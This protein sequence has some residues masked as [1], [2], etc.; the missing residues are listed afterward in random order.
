MP[1]ATSADPGTVILGPSDAHMAF[2]LAQA[3]GNDAADLITVSQLSAYQPGV[4]IGAV[5]VDSH[6]VLSTWGISD[7]NG[8]H[9][10]ADHMAGITDQRYRF[11]TADV[12]RPGKWF[13]RLAVA[14]ETGTAG[15]FW[16]AGDLLVSGNV[17][18]YGVFGT[19]L[20]LWNESTDAW[21][22]T[23]SNLTAAPVNTG[24]AFAGTGTL[25]LFI[26][27]G[28]SG[29]ATYTGAVFANVAASGTVPAA[30]A[31]CVF[32]NTSL[33]CLATNGQ[34]W[35]SVD[36]TA[37][38]SFGADGKVD[39]ALTANWIYE[40]RDV[41]GNPVLMVVTT[42]GVFSFDPA[43]PTLY[44]LDL[45]FPN[46]PSQGLTACNWR[47]EQYIAVGLGV[48]SF[49]GSNIGAMG[50]DRDEGLPF[51][52][53][54]DA[55]IVSL[56][57]EYNDMYALVQGDNTNS[58]A[59]VQKWTGSG[60][61]SV[62]ERGASATVTRLYVSGARSQHRLWWGGGN[63]SYTIDLPIA[64]TNPRQL[65]ANALGSFDSG[66]VYL[67][68]GLT[69]MGM[70]G[71]KFIGVAAGIY[72]D[73]P[74]DLITL[75]DAPVVKYRLADERSFTTCSG[76]RNENG[77]I[78]VPDGSVRGSYFYWLD[79]G[80][81]GVRFEEIE[82]RVEWTLPWLLK[83]VALYF[84]KVISGNRA[85]TVTLD[86]TE[87]FED[88]SPE[89]MEQAI[90]NYIIDENIID[91]IYRDTTYKVRVSSWSGADSSGRADTRGMRSVQ[92]IEVHDRP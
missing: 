45:Q 79:S 57:G 65:Y 35:Y 52:L 87:K 49:T 37:W 20:H 53:G 24:V 75:A 66:T 54:Y 32:G 17:E 55:K 50:L 31:F 89:L 64:F 18:M 15:A 43:G 19:D 85:W 1:L 91:F 30:K 29:Y 92:L 84:T 70:P 9:G 72:V 81:E 77:S 6:P 73:T 4:T 68:T 28:A 59:S 36:G 26:P 3:R 71:S 10:M 12:T 40:D 48:H 69:N 44:Q 88:V 62:W 58:F 21:T 27:M 7:L 74:E 11:G 14:T 67:E 25:R 38:T 8:G 86:L 41:M 39:G 76:P 63:N 5:D 51:N 46:H 13:P 47:G 33:I 80:F 2:K 16:P 90:D 42:G 56:V 60:W 34:L 61:H 23:T 83:G 82:L 78:Y 22:D